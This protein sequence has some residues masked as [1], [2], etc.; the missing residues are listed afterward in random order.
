M[1]AAQS[2]TNAVTVVLEAEAVQRGQPRIE[3]DVAVRNDGA[4]PV[5]LLNPFEMVQIIVLDANGFPKRVPKPVPSLLIN[6]KGQP[7]WKLRTAVPVVRVLHSGR[8]VNA[9]TLDTPVLTMD[10]S[11]SY[12]VRFAIDHFE[13]EP[14]PTASGVAEGAETPG[15]GEYSVQVVLNLIN[16]D[17]TRDSRVVRP[18]RKTVTLTP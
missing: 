7:N 9:S 1:L 5:R 6:T 10:P 11:E 18:D 3:V 15:W 16:A 13:P 2:G 4:N 8:D 12:Q 17:D 14:D